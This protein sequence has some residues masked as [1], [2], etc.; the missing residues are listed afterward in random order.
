MVAVSPTLRLVLLLVMAMVGGMVSATTVLTVMDTALLMSVPSAFM[1]P[2]ASLN[3]LLP[4]LILAAVV[5]LAAGVK[6]AV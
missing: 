4:T 6:V 3:L 1:L 2:A 5:L